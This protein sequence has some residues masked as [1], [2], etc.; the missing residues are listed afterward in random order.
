PIITFAD[1]L[2]EWFE[3]ILKSALDF[4]SVT[5]RSVPDFS[6]ADR[7][8]SRSPSLPTPTRTIFARNA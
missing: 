5:V 8:R 7:G 3:I 4:Q 6:T 2:R 1:S